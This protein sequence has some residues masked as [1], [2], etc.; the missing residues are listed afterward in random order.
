M[1]IGITLNM[2]VAFWANGMQQNIVFL[3][4]L[5]NR[6]GN[7]CYYITHEDPKYSIHKNHKGMILKDLLSDNS[8]VFDVLFVACF[9]LTEEMY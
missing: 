4:S 6:A 8:E 3:Y 2:Y 7:D 1:K 5:L 9:D